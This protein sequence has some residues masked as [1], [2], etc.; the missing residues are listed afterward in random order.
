M[1]KAVATGKQLSGGTEWRNW[2]HW[3]RRRVNIMFNLSKNWK[4]LSPL[5]CEYFHFKY[6]LSSWNSKFLVYVRWKRIWIKFPDAFSG[7][8]DICEASS[9]SAFISG[10]GGNFQLF[11]N[12][13]HRRREIRDLK[14]NGKFTQDLRLSSENWKSFNIRRPEFWVGISN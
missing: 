10:C 12:R 6:L 5:Y 13:F 8:G 1:L 9:F 4:F 14:G 3:G 2:S 7:R 11:S